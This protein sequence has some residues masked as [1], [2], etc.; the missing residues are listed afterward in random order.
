MFSQ[1]AYSVDE[2]SGPAQPVLVLGRRKRSATVF[3]VQI[4]ETANTA[5]SEQTNIII[6]MFMQSYRK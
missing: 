5:T 6:L 2:D 1:P 4:R 3:T